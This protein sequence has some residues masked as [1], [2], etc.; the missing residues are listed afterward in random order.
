ML[1][2]P[3][4]TKLSYFVRRER[5]HVMVIREA[6]SSV[7]SKFNLCEPVVEHT[8]SDYLTENFDKLRHY[9][10]SKGIIDKA[11]DLLADVYITLY[12]NECQGNSFD[13]EYCGG[14]D[15]MTVGKYVRSMIKKYAMSRKYRSDIIDSKSHTATYNVTT[16]KAIL[17]ATGEEM[18][19]ANGNTMYGLVTEKKKTKIDHIVYAAMEL[20][21]TDDSSPRDVNAIDWAYTT[22]FE[23]ESQ[24]KF[25]EVEE[26]AS[27][28]SSLDICV[29][30]ANKYNFD[31]L[32]LLKRIDK[33]GQALAEI[34]PN[35][36]EPLES[37]RIVRQIAD[38]NDQ[39]KDALEDVLNYSMSN[40][41]KFESILLCCKA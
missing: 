27:I 6:T 11:D 29:D 28:E 4:E 5:V 33:I 14:D 24:I 19:D 15:L 13:M 8:A 16:K 20:T 17:S 2:I 3:V 26:S 9:A 34:K 31:I 25:L 12:T 41:E 39:F 36:E 23:E 30:I 37:F 22:A 21:S 38:E 40:K 35:R 18:K 32:S 10:N 1:F 7:V